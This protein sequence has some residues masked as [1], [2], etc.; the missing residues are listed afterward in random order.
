VL[1]H[2][3]AD[4]SEEG[5]DVRN[6]GGWGR[7]RGCGFAVQWANALFGD[8][9]G[10]EESWETS[11]LGVVQ[12]HDG[13]ELNLRTD[14]RKL[15][16]GLVVY[17]GLVWV[18]RSLGIGGP[19]QDRNEGGRNWPEGSLSLDGRVARGFQLFGRAEKF[20]S[21]SQPSGSTILRGA[22]MVQLLGHLPAGA[23]A[24]FQPI[25][26]HFSFLRD[27]SAI[28]NLIYFLIV[29]QSSR[30]WILVISILQF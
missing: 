30:P 12:S 9:E 14:S 10:L 4:Q 17:V 16:S 23:L 7:H 3:T 27:D 11:D 28:G 25:Y 1:G 24:F 22:F 2:F 21:H 29:F 15:L 26:I 13:V 20:R 5:L 19:P 6:E 18:D 8:V